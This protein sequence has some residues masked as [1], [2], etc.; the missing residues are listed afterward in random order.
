MSIV[1][2]LFVVVSIHFQILLT[3]QSQLC[4]SA[5]QQVVE[6]AFFMSS[7]LRFPDNESIF[8]HPWFVAEERMAFQQ[9]LVMTF[10]K[11]IDISDEDQLQS[12][13]TD[14][15]RAALLSAFL[16]LNKALQEGVKSPGHTKTICSVSFQLL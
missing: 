3:L 15:A 9:G 13:A 16:T 6:Y 10:N 14:L 8:F 12:S 1:S 11:L 5:Q 2:N 4:C 7:S